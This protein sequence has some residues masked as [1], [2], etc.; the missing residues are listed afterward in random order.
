MMLP[1]PFRLHAFERIDSTND[2]ARRQALSGAP[3]FT[4]V[5]A[6]EQSAGRGRRGNSWVSPAGN[7]H[8]SLLL[9]P[10]GSAAAAAQLGFAAALA[11]AET[12]ERLV[13]AAAV[14]VKWPNDVLL[15]GGKV[16]GILLESRS[17]GDGIDFLVIGIGVNLAAHPA[18][19]PYPATSLAAW[20]AE[21]TPDRALPIL[22][23][24]L[25]A[26]YEAW[27]RG[28]AALRAAWLARAAG[29]GGPIRV[30]LQE[31]EVA[32]RFDGLDETGRLLLGTAEGRRAIAAG[33]VFPAS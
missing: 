14:A 15:G 19:T 4:L 6:R 20:G 28:F 32:G 7:L 16:A 11:A 21:V 17:A 26:W 9:R 33:E 8:C 24:R 23:A 31:G 2:E 10:K 25:L 5:L 3:E 29:V 22:G 1:H 27:G 12:V 18:D 30:R 13:S